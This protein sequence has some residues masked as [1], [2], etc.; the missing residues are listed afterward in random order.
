MHQ[1]VPQCGCVEGVGPQML[2]RAD[3]PGP[4]R[5]SSGPWDQG[6]AQL[7]EGCRKGRRRC[8]FPEP[9]SPIPRC[10]RNGK[11]VP[12]QLGDTGQEQR[13]VSWGHL[14]SLTSLSCS[15][16]ERTGPLWP[17]LAQLGTSVKPGSV[18]WPLPPGGVLPS[19]STTN[20]VGLPCNFH[21]R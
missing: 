9:T 7:L 12:D 21:C 14:P 19:Q 20:G 4:G 3:Q 2:C 10:W 13:V 11:G 1:A 16:W 18:G 8:W 15:V 6:L 17:L 5:T